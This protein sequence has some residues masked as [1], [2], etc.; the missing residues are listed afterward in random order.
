MEETRNS[1]E[2]AQNNLAE[3]QNNLE[4][5]QNN[6]EETQN[7]LD[8]MNEKYDQSIRNTVEILRDMGL[9]DQ[10]IISKLSVKYQLAEN[11][12]KKYLYDI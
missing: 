3:T 12:I 9:H 6:L 8:E 11:Q 2:E 1:L 7:N 10:E 5:A 4:E